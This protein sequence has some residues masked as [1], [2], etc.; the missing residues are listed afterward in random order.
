[1]AKIESDICI[2]GGGISSALQPES[3]RARWRL[4]DRPCTGRDT[5]IAF[6]KRIYACAL[7]M[8][9]PWIGRSLGRN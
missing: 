5:S 4:A 1:M 7:F 9:S 3:L 6:Q 2:I 8:A